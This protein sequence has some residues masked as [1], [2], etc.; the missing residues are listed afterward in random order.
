MTVNSKSVA[1]RYP[2]QDLRY[3]VKSLVSNEILFYFDEDF[4]IRLI[5]DPREEVMA[6][7]NLRFAQLCP[8]KHL[9]VYGAPEENL[10]K[11]KASKRRRSS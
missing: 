3:L 5:L 11:Y 4:D 6:L 10:Y 7:I 8:K 9:R 2:I 1:K